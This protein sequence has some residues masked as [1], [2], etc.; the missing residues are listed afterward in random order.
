M[1]SVLLSLLTAGVLVP[2]RGLRSLLKSRQRRQAK[3]AG[4]P[5]LTRKS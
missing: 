5:Q 4:L 2:A 1:M 3:A